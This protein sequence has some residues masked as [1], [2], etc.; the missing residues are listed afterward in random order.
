MPAVQVEVIIEVPRGGHEKLRADGSRDFLSPLPC[1]FNYG[2]VPGT[3]SGDGDP[4]DALVLGPRLPRGTRV[5]VDV[6]AEVRFVDAGEPDP[7][8]VCGE[9]LG[10]VDQLRVALFFRGYALAKRALHR[11]RGRR[12]RTAYE[13]IGAASFSPSTTAR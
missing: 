12:G 7:K 9:R 6:L 5:R 13:G 3:V 4:L 1:P 2:S 10:R 11:L 8:L